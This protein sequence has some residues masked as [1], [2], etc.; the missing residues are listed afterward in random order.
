MYFWLRENWTLDCTVTGTPDIGNDEIDFLAGSPLRAPI[1]KPIIFNSNFKCGDQPHHYFDYGT[2]I[3]AVSRKFIDALISANVDN[4]EFFPAVLK[5][6]D[7]QWSDY[8]A[9]NVLG[10]VDAV[11]LDSSI[12]D[13]VMGGDEDGMPP[14]GIFTAIA[15]HEERICSLEFFREPIGNNLIISE[16]VFD[17]LVELLPGGIMGVVAHEVVLT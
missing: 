8:F 7:Q 10:M 15:L 6:A 17:K 14:L 13:E 16:R 12:Y 1:E 5:G 4:F 9:L 2:C 3:P 11:D